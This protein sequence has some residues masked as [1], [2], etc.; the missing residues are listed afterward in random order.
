MLDGFYYFVFLDVRV[1]VAEK[2]RTHP[3]KII[4]IKKNIRN[5]IKQNFKKSCQFAEIMKSHQINES[6]DI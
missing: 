3:I 6:I 5:R 4:Q 2:W 1:I